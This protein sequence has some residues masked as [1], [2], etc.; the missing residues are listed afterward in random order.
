MKTLTAHFTEAELD[1]LAFLPG[2]Y[3]G[4]SFAGEA[5]SIR[6]Y[7]ASVAERALRQGAERVVLVIPNDIL[8][9]G[10]GVLKSTR[11]ILGLRCRG[12]LKE[13]YAMYDATGFM[14]VR[15]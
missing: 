15:A 2:N 4:T 7:V 3:A 12:R 14:M 10:H 1:S 6:A 13:L 11:S 5:P 8:R 9:R